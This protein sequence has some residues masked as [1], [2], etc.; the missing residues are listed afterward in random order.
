MKSDLRIPSLDGLRAISIILVIFSHTV[1]KISDQIHFSNITFYLNFGAL[2][3]RIFFVISGFL[4]T[5]LLLKELAQTDNINLLKFYFRRTMR[6]FVPFYFFLIIIFF[7]SNSGLTPPIPFKTF[8]TAITYNSNYISNSNWDITHSWSLSVEEQFY[9]LFPGILAFLG[10]AKT[11]K[12]LLAAL[13]IAPASRLWYFFHYGETDFFWFT[14]AFHHN[15]DA[16]AIGGL[17]SLFREEL[18]KNQI[19]QYFLRKNFALLLP[20]LIVILN[21][22]DDHPKFAVS[23]GISAVNLLIVLFLDWVVVNHESL[24]G[25]VLN[26]RP[27]I[28]IGMMSYSIYLWQQP[29]FN[30]DNKAMFA[31]FPYNLGALILASILSYYL[32]EKKSL[33]LRQSLENKLFKN[34]TQAIPVVQT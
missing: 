30:P 21:N 4:I 33:L 22:Q 32:I 17:L 28:L 26:S 12:F 23:A 18:H 8:L 16:L 3:V 11:K 27:M 14:T 10:V 25:K 7:T 31:T 5:G 34:K 19:Y 13:L 6:I 20:I 24:V 15:M 1:T 2:G 29:F 9:L